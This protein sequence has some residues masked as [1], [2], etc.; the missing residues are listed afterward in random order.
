MKLKYSFENIS[1]EAEDVFSKSVE[2]QTFD[3]LNFRVIH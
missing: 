2:E 1:S 3:R